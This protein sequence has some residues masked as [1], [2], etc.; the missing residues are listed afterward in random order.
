[1]GSGTSVGGSG[2]A[3][4]GCGEAAGAV[5][6]GWVGVVSTIGVMAE[7]SAGP[8]ARAQARA[9]ARLTITK[10]Q[11]R[12]A[13]LRGRVVRFKEGLSGNGRKLKAD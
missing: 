1:V 3:S 10:A 11:K 4:P 8:S 5:G 7:R 6:A 9:A 13:L 2:E 12:Q